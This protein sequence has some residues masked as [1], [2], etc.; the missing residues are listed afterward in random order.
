MVTAAVE[1]ERE[2]PV[3]GRQVE[4]VGQRITGRR[5]PRA[6]RERDLTEAEVLHLRGALTAHLDQR[7]AD[8]DR[9]TG[10]KGRPLRQHLEVVDLGQPPRP[11]SLRRRGQQAGGIQV[12]EGE[13]TDILTKGR[14]DPCVGIRAVP[15]GEAMMACVLAEHMMRHRAQVGSAPV[16]V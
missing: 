11:H 15:V 4:H 14:H 5:H 12:V 9:V 13:E 16:S 2:R 7:V 1:D 3:P 8:P 6:A 10:V